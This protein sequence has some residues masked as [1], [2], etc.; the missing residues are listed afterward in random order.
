MPVLVFGTASLLSLLGCTYVLEIWLLQPDVL[1]C[2][3][4]LGLSAQLSLLEAINRSLP[5]FVTPSWGFS[6]TA[7]DMML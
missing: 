3:H 2:E 4:L 7:T 1:L 5:L 6:A